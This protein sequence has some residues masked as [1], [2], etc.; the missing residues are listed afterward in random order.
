MLARGPGEKKKEN[1]RRQKY[2]AKMRE[3]TWTWIIPGLPLPPCPLKSC[4]MS[5]G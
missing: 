2:V 4:D 5:H 1:G 3:E